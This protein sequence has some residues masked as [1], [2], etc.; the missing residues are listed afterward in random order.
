[1]L[2]MLATDAFTEPPPDGQPTIIRKDTA[3]YTFGD[4]DGRLRG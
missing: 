1:M 4:D 2:L 3:S